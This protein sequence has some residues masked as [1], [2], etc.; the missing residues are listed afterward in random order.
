ML[1]SIYLKQK[2]R[3]LKKSDLSK[4]KKVRSKIGCGKLIYRNDTIKCGEWSGGDQHFCK[5]CFD[6]KQLLKELMKQTKDGK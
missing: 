6:N 5:K 3:D 4:N 2:W 1:L